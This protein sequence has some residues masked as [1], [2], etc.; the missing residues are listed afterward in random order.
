ALNRWK[1]ILQPRGSETRLGE[2][3]YPLISQLSGR[4][5]RGGV[6]VFDGRC[7]AGLDTEPAR[8]RAERTGTRLITVGMG[9]QKPQMNLR[10]AGMQSPTDVHQG[11]PFDVT[12]M[13]Q[14]T[15]SEGKQATIHLFQQTADGD[16]SDRREVA[17]QSVELNEDAIPVSVRFSQ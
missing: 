1:A 15:G 8:T 14:G 11:D 10:V 3:P 5:L 7:D 4:T 12:V 6:V 16:G 13:I 2:S 17:Q 9:S